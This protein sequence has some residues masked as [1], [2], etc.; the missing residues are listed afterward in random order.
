MDNE[1]LGT[2]QSPKCR[3]ELW[4]KE[5]G[6]EL[7]ARNS[8]HEIIYED[9]VPVFDGSNLLKY[10]EERT[11]FRLG[12]TLLD[13]LPVGVMLGGVAGLGISTQHQNTPSGLA[14]FGIATFCGIGLQTI[15]KEF[16]DRVEQF[17]NALSTYG[18]NR[19]T[20]DNS[21]I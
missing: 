11:P 4:K 6:Y 2:R 5:G 8:D 9:S 21:K 10:S 14:I 15:I 16:S 18:F 19:L 13:L 1:R 17:N 7:I 12:R 3:A 20:R